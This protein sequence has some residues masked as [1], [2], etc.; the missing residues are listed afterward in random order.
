[1]LATTSTAAVSLPTHDVSSTANLACKNAVNVILLRPSIAAIKSVK[2]IIE[3]VAA[4]VIVKV[5]DILLAHL[6]RHVQT[7]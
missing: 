1:M 5:Y 4:C 3:L 6:T 2:L 7:A